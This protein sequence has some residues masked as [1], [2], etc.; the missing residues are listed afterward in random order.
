MDGICGTLSLIG[1]PA[2]SDILRRMIA[3]APG[4]SASDKSDVVV[5]S[6]CGLGAWWASRDSGVDPR[7][8]Q[9]F[10]VVYSPQ[11]SRAIDT[12]EAWIVCNGELYNFSE[13]RN[14]LVASKHRFQT[15]S[16]IETLLRAY[17]QFGEQNFIKAFRGVFAFAIW[18]VKR[19]RLLLMR[20]R[21]GNI[22][23]YYA[24]TSN[25]LVFSTSLRAL[26]Q[27]PEV[28]REINQDALF[29]YLEHGYIPSPLTLIRD[30]YSVPPGHSLA[31]DSSKTPVSLDLEAFWSPPSP[32]SSSDLRDEDDIAAD[33]L[34]H[35]RWST[36]MRMRYGGTPSVLLDGTVESAALAGLAVQET[37]LAVKS[38]TITSGN[39][40]EEA[41]Y[42]RQVAT[43]FVTDHY[44]FN[45]DSDLPSF[46]EQA[47]RDADQPFS[48]SAFFSYAAL[49]QIS[50][51]A[52][53]LLY[54]MGVSA[55]FSGFEYV[56]TLG[57]GS[58][59][60]WLPSIAQKV[61]GRS[62]DSLNASTL[63]S[64]LTKQAGQWYEAH[65]ARIH[66]V[67][68]E[69]LDSLQNRKT[70]ALE[71]SAHATYLESIQGVDLLSALIDLSVR[72]ELPD[73]TVSAL[74]A[75][76]STQ[77]PVIRTPYVDHQFALFA[78]G[79]P[80]KLKFKDSSPRY[81]FRRAL[82]SLIPPRL[83]RHRGAAAEL[84]VGKW[85][86]ESLHTIFNDAILDL[87]VSDS[88]IDHPQMVRQFWEEHQAGAR[89]HGL[90][91]WRLAVY[92]FWK[93]NLTLN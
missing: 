23:L 48:P 30:V 83:L 43:H 31:V 41:R 7:P 93:Q 85:M 33:L 37:G 77:L 19:K 38:F 75:C 58:S 63:L 35:I 67:P 3:G 51:S 34:A 15:N 46:M 60:G 10:G 81:I 16:D 21:F 20:D 49:R 17:L 13:I 86:L 36:R 40:L 72:T 62:G 79:V 11:T 55:L 82:Q 80:S 14:A 28:G 18:D 4:T 78:Y 42:S 69:I 54:P 59:S 61:I 56:D 65:L 44:E 73:Q 57:S 24:R 39:L 25:H 74:T 26:L 1:E 87:S 9:P 91:L 70:S 64:P 52:D 22:P 71:R 50:S 89:D 6:R 76:Q 92:H 5:S 45:L 2:N 53:Y 8:Q 84:P 32:A 27:H 66:T 90:I 29:Y 68:S 47:V 12:G 88:G